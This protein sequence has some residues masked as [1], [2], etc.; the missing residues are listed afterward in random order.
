MHLLVTGASGYLGGYLLQELATRSHTVSAWSGTRAGVVQGHPVVPVDLM[1][2]DRVIAAFGATRPDGV[3][4]AAG[5]AN[6]AECYR[7]PERAQ[8]V[9]VGGTALLAELAAGAKARLVFVSTDLVFDGA[10]SNYR[11][12]D[13][14]APVSVY[15]R[16]KRDAEQAVLAWPGNAVARI[17]WLFG[18]TLTGR[19]SFFDQQVAALRQGRPLSLFTDEWRTPLSIAVAAQALVELGVSDFTGLLH[20]GGPERLSRWEMGLR[21]AA[22]L[23]VDPTCLC[24]CERA[25]VAGGEPRPRDVALDATR[26]RRLFPHLP[27]P[28]WEEALRAMLPG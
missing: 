18:P 28:N 25:S 23:G 19:E 15:G 21:L 6:V 13:A 11:E 14:P 7:Q 12:E 24:P 26:W 17:S 27:W 10:K 1:D 9:N 5:M 16:T 8:Q 22:F 3:I 20:I 2:R 4:H